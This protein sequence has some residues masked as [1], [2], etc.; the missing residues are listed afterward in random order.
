MTAQT[1][2]FVSS[3]EE[4]H[5]EIRGALERCNYAVQRLDVDVPEIQS[6]NPADV[7]T[8]KAR[9]ADRQIESGLVLVEDTGLGVDAWGGYPGALI[10]W[11]LKSVGEAGLCRQ[12]DAWEDRRATATVVLCLF[13]GDHLHTFTGQTTGVIAA[14]PRGTFGFGWD[15]IFQPDGYAITYG[16]MPREEKMKISMRAQALEHL[17]A[18]LTGAP[19]TSGD[20]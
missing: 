20:A 2:T 11:V 6:I 12:L 8:Y 4:K 7:A 14:S 15:S 9:A 19:T 13:D 17:R 10:K 1:I 5:R 16:E 3:N 18:F